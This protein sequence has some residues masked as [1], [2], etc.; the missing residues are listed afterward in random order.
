MTSIT[1]QKTALVFPN[2]I[3][4]EVGHKKVHLCVCGVWCV[5]VCVRV[6]LYILYS[7]TVIII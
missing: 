6:A 5:C 4:I 2:A 3:L 7:G 1:K